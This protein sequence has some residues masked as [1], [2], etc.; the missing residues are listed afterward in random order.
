MGELDLDKIERLLEPEPAPE[1]LWQR[2][3]LVIEGEVIDE[4]PPHPDDD[5]CPA[6]A[7]K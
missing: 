2:R 1:R 3:P 6:E 4:A 7:R 5:K